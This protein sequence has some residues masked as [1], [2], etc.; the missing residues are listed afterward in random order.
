[1]RITSGAFSDGR[2]LDRYGGR[3]GNFIGPVSPLSLP[4]EI[5]GAPEGTVSFAVV[6]SDPDAVVPQGFVWYHWLIAGLKRTSLP[7]GASRDD[8]SLVQGVTSWYPKRIPE[9]A[10][11]CFYG[12]PNPPDRPH[13]Y[14]LTAYALDTDPGLG[15]GFTLEDLESA[16]DGHVLA[17]ASI[18]G[19]Y[20]PRDRN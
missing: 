16:M 11:A 1:M 5:S 12:G 14:V 6:F 19:I 8:P 4:F 7:E 13:R 18:E 3:S 2:I 10:D 20:P 15:T 9:K 17:E